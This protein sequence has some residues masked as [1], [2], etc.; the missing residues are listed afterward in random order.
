MAGGW[1]PERPRRRLAV[2]MI[3][4]LFGLTRDARKLQQDMT[5]SGQIPS[6]RE[7]VGQA[8]GQLAEF[9]Q[10]QSEAP[11]ILAEG[12]PATAIIRDMGTPERGAAWFNL[13]LDL[14]VHPRTG[15][16]YRVANDYLVPAAAHL[17]PGVELSVRVDPDD[18]SKIAIEWD[19]APEGPKL[20]EIRPV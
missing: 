4:D 1:A 17:E 20:G 9:G 7:L 14:E 2:G 3:R 6:M 15:Q 13:V 18:R 8:R 11:R 16:A 10:M 19:N 12:V 5:Q